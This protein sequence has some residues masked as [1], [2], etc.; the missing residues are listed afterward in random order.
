V[1]CS[2]DQCATVLA[3]EGVV[4]DALMA[5]EMSSTA[6]QNLLDA[7]TVAVGSLLILGSALHSSCMR[8]STTACALRGLLVRFR[9]SR[10]PKRV[11][12]HVQC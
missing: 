7:C 4:I 6:F 2:S 11:C 3:I 8:L 5:V 1:H 9:S 12:I 10:V